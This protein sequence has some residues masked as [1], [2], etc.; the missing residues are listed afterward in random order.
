MKIIQDDREPQLQL[1]ADTLEL[2][3]EFERK[4]MNIGDYSYP[5]IIV[6][7]KT[8]DDFCSSIMDNRIKTQVEKMKGT[9]EELIMI[10]VGSIKERTANVHEHCILGK[11]SS[12]VIKHGLKLFFVDDEF[13]FIYLLKNIIDKYTQIKMKGGE[14]DG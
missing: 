11:I 9:D 1:L 13:Q 4:R 8:I 7:R 5:G 12:L 6:E 3:I 2:D 10:V 14:I